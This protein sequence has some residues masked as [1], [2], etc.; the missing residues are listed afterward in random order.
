M[1]K[2]RKKRQKDK[3]QCKKRHTNTIIR[4]IKHN[5]YERKIKENFLLRKTKWIETRNRKQG[6]HRKPAEKKTEKNLNKFWPMIKV[7]WPKAADCGRLW[8]A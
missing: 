7:S 4:I 8:I 5:D 6:N 3:T 1:K 2:V